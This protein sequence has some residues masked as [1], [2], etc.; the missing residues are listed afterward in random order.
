MACNTCGGV[1]VRADYNSQTQ[2]QT[3][4]DLDRLYQLRIEQNSV[5]VQNTNPNNIA[6]EKDKVYSNQQIR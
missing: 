2:Q 1:K 4:T 6:F 3:Q 5:T